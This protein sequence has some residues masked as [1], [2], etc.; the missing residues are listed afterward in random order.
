MKPEL[1]KYA[2]VAWTFLNTAGY[3]NFGVA[4]DLIARAL[5]TAPTRGTVIV[6]GAGLAGDNFELL[7]RTPQALKNALAEDCGIASLHDVVGV[8]SGLSAARQLRAFGFKV[9][10]LEG[11]AR[12]GG[13]VYTKRLQVHTPVAYLSQAQAPK[14]ALALHRAS[15]TL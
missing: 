10:I 2:R 8:L 11:H 1:R 15:L 5:K 7:L 13:R 6:V 9:V 12:P 3:I 4:P 14:E